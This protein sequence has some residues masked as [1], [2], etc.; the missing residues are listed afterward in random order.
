[1]SGGNQ[2]HRPARLAPAEGRERLTC[3]A[4]W[5]PCPPTRAWPARTQRACCRSCPARRSSAAQLLRQPAAAEKALRDLLGEVEAALQALST[6]TAG[7][8]LLRDGPAR[9][10][11]ATAC[12]G[13]MD[14]A[15]ELD[16]LLDTPGSL[17]WD[18]DS[19]ETVQGVLGQLTDRLYSVL[20]D[21]VEVAESARALH[22]GQATPRCAL[23]YLAVE[24]VLQTV[25]RLEV[26]GRDSAG[27]SIWVQLDDADRAALRRLAHRPGRSAAAQQVGRGDRARRVLR[28]QA[29]R[30]RRQAGRQRR[31]AAPGP[32]R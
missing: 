11:L 17:G 4:S 28:L 1:M 23:S 13:L 29:R 10:E 8:E 32:A 7:I 27:V 26:R 30:H 3:V 19:V 18:A 20:H 25:N 16:R 31:R 21:R 12:S 22:P 9:Q 15:A 24:T 14:W 5:Q 2:A 6:E